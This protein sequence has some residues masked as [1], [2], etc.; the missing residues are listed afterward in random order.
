MFQLLLTSN[1]LNQKGPFYDEMKSFI[2]SGILSGGKYSIVLFET[3]K[4]LTTKW[5][6]L[7]YA[8]SHN[9][10]IIF[11]ILENTVVA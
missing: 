4:L 2:G 9:S 3:I 7:A 1:Q 8:R 6:S 5:K 11:L 10:F